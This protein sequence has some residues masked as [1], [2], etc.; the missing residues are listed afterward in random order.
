M[1]PDMAAPILES[2]RV[3]YSIPS[4]NKLTSRTSWFSTQSY[5]NQNHRKKTS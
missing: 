1:D 3:G 5:Q 2:M 4:R